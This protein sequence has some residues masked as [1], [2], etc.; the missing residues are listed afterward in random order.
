MSFNPLTR[1]SEL[2]D[3]IAIGPFHQYESIGN[4]VPHQT[5]QFTL[6]YTLEKFFNHFHF[7]FLETLGEKERLC[8]ASY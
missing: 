3:T 7:T 1:S 8:C 4:F 6:L 5:T 2:L